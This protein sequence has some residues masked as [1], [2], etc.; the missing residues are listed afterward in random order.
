M[1]AYFRLYTQE[2]TNSRR[3]IAE[4]RMAA[5]GVVDGMDAAVKL[6]KDGFP[7]IPRIAAARTGADLRPR[8]PICDGC[9]TFSGRW[10]CRRY[11]ARI[12]SGG[13][14]AALALGL[15]SSAKNGT[16]LSSNHQSVLQA[17]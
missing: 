10:R 4:G 14:H 9:N 17:E 8:K 16:G 5:S 3:G 7:A 15:V 12:L 1:N 11:S 6:P 2:H 13:N